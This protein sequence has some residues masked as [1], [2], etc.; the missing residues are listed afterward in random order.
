MK[1]YLKRGMLTIPLFLYTF[2]SIYPLLWVL[3]QSF[4]TEAN[5]LADPW[6]LPESWNVANY[7]SAWSNANFGTYYNNSILVTGVTLLIALFITA[8]AGYA[9]ARLRF[10]GQNVLLMLIVA[11]LLV[12]VP[13]LLLP[14][15]FITRDL[16]LLNSYG[17]LIGPYVAGAVPLGVLVM[18]NYFQSIPYEL[19]DAARIDG[20][21]EY[22][23]FFRVMLPLVTPALATVSMLVFMDVWNEYMWALISLSDQKLYTIPIGMATMEAKKFV[24]GNT[25]VFAG[26]VLSTIVIISLFI[27]LQRYFLKAMSEGAVKG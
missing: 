22:G 20:C 24:Y 18:R 13:V 23:I 14:V 27:F 26:M 11:V 5:F 16:G 3:I 19:S 25:T 12:P 2:V 7:A 9:F 6:G 21:N 1:R 10:T 8:L 17:G 4:K 15:Y